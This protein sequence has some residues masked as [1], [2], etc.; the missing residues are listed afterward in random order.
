MRIAVPHRRYLGHLEHELRWDGLE[1]SGENKRPYHLGASRKV[2]G[3]AAI[4]FALWIL[5]ATSR[6]IHD[7][8]PRGYLS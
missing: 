6:E 8:P 7:S 5:Q 2:Q 1:L 3:L 4:R